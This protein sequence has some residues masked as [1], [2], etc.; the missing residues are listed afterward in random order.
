MSAIPSTTCALPIFASGAL[1]PVLEPW[2][3]SFSGHF[4]YYPGRRYLPAPQ[5]AFVDFIK[6][7]PAA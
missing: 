1:E 5:R 7:Q 2:W 6:H 3:E 4:L